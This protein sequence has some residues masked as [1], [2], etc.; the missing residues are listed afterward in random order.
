VEVHVFSRHHSL[1]S[2]LCLLSILHGHSSQTGHNPEYGPRP[3]DSIEAA[4]WSV[5]L[6]ATHPTSTNGTLPSG[7][8]EAGSQDTL[9]DQLSS[10]QSA[11][12]T[13]VEE[14]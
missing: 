11:A 1:L 12:T 2:L 7:P 13:T 9:T 8:A 4:R 14:T 6:V 3:V 10:E 5:E